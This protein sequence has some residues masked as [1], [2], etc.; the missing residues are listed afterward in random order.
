MAFGCIGK[1]DKTDMLTI[2]D[3]KIVQIQPSV[4][5]GRLILTLQGLK[6]K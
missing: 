4:L 6:L 3:P 2:I 5:V 1:I